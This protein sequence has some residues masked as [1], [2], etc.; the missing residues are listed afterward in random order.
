MNFIELYLAKLIDNFKM[1]SPKIYAAVV[2]FLGTII[3]LC[4]NGLGDLIGAE[5]ANV[6]KYATIGI[7]M[8]TGSRTTAMLRNSK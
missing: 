3:Y 8:L 2:L 4:E 6:V 1:A 5:L 7:G